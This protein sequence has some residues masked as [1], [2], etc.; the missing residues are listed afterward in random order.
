M[1]PQV[2]GLF[3]SSRWVEH[4]VKVEFKK[5]LPFAHGGDAEAQ[6]VGQGLGRSVEA[7]FEWRSDYAHGEERVLYNLSRP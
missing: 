2:P 5:G 3:Y 1:T 4:G 6:M 7:V